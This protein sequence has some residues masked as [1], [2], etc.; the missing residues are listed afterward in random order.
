LIFQSNGNKKDEEE[1]AAD[2]DTLHKFRQKLH[3]PKRISEKSSESLN[4]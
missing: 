2:V 4:L 1:L 3:A